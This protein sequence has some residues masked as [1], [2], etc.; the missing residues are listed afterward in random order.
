MIT[1]DSRYATAVHEQAT[2][3][4]YSDLGVKEVDSATKKPVEVS[5]DTTYLLT[6]G[7]AAPP[8]RHYMAKET[9]DFQLLAYRTLQDPTRWWV[10][11][12]ANPH[13]RYPLDLKMGDALYLPE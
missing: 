4:L 3:H 2:A 11:A 5:R 9:D 6:T 1:S 13:I 7:T 12:N 8:P 10:L